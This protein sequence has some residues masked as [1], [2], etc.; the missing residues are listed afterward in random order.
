MGN[1]L[2]HPLDSRGFLSS[3]Q[4]YLTFEQPGPG[5]YVCVSLPIV[6]SAFLPPAHPSP[7]VSIWHVQKVSLVSSVMWCLGGCQL[8]GLPRLCIMHCTRLQSVAPLAPQVPPL[9]LISV[10][11][12]N[13]RSLNNVSV[14]PRLVNDSSVILLPL[15]PTSLTPRNPL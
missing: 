1:Q 12:F 13:Q 10:S 8:S 4:C 7:V 15:R 2:R 11:E 14:I 6:A 3:G 5:H 9:A